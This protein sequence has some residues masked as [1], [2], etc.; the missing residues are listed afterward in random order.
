MYNTVLIE[1]VVLIL[2]LER[3]LNSKSAPVYTI[4]KAILTSLFI[5]I[6]FILSIRLNHGLVAI[7]IGLI[8]NKILT[9]K[10][11]STTKNSWIYEL[12]GD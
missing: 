2:E 12:P 11:T 9:K 10:I 1:F 7:Q 6:L 3:D 5:W 8:N 4:V